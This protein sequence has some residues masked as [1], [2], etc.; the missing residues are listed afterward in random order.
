[1][2]RMLVSTY[3]ITSRSSVVVVVVVV[4]VAVAVVVVVVIVVVVV[5]VEVEVFCGDNP[6]LLGGDPMVISPPSFMIDETIKVPTT[7][8]TSTTNIGG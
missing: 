4:V 6:V 3:I 2:L 5:F 7:H 8:Q 1:M